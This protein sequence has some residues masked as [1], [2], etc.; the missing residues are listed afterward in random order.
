MANDDQRRAAQYLAANSQWHVKRETRKAIILHGSD[1]GQ[2][3]RVGLMDVWLEKR[4]LSRHK[5]LWIVSAPLR[6]NVREL[7]DRQLRHLARSAPSR[8]Q[9]SR[10]QGA[11][12]ATMDAGPSGRSRWR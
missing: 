3:L 10:G 6:L 1:P 4:L 9:G 5:I 12:V 8:G 7:S 2:R 11:G